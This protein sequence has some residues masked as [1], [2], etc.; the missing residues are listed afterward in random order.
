MRPL[1]VR[2]GTLARRCNTELVS[3]KEPAE[4]DLELVRSL[5]EEHVRR[6]ASP[7]GIKLLY[8]F[9]EA[10]A[11]FVKVIARDYERVLALVAEAEAAGA[12]REAALSRAFDAMREG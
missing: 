11:H 2:D 4:K 9:E 5:V 10:S 6:T 3:L 8:Q 1:P 12:T 7:R